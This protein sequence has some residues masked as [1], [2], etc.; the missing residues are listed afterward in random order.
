MHPIAFIDLSRQQKQI[1][2][3]LDA[4]IGRVLNHGQY[5]MGPEVGQLERSLGEFCGAR[6]VVACANGTDALLL[7]L[8]A[9]DLRAGD[10]VIMPSFTFCATAEPVSLLGGVPIFADVLEDTFNLDPESL[11]AA[12]LTARRLK[13]PLRG[14]ISVD[15][16]GQPC[17]YDAIEA[18][19]RPMTAA[20][21]AR[22][23]TSRRRA[24]SRPSRWAA[25]GTAVRSL[26]TRTKPRRSSGRYAST[27]KAKTNTTMSGSASMAASIQFKPRSC[28]RNWPSLPMRSRHAAGL[29]HGMTRCCRAASND[30]L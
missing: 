9:K 20:R 29:L 15:L 17:D 18:L 5:I 25:T 2:H 3:E 1:R 27:A 13:L 10:A 24:S 14:V 28:S 16:F 21:S 8:I 19:A 30:P 12:V 26:P 22:S 7:A 23:G 11:K 4:A 6:H